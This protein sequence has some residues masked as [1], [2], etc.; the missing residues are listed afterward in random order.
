LTFVAGATVM[1]SMPPMTLPEVAFCG[2]S[3]VGKSSIINALTLSTTARSSDKPGMTQQ[4]NFYVLPRRLMMVDMPGYGFAFANEQKMAGWK[5]LID[6][7][8]QTRKMKRVFLIIDGRHG[9]KQNDKDFMQRLD[10]ARV[11]FQIILTK[12]DLV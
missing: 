4:F 3:N 7:Y 1:S 8:I 11:S 5:V 10:D 2:R 6:Q 9:V 12:C